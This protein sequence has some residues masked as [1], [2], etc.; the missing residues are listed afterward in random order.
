M[1][2]IVQKL[3]ENNKKASEVFKFDEKRLVSFGNFV[4]A[5]NLLGIEEFAIEDTKLVLQYLQ[6]ED[7]EKI[8]FSIDEFEDVLMS[9]ENEDSVETKNIQSPSFRSNY[10]Y[11]EDYESEYSDDC[12]D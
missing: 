5:M 11:S 3:T 6:S 4:K 7:S 10:Q 8:C 9:C 12:D 2:K 1:K